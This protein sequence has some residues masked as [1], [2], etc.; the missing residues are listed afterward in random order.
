MLGWKDVLGALSGSRGGV[1][2]HDLAS[3]MGIDPS[4]EASL[5]GMLRRCM[6]YGTVGRTKEGRQHLY[7][8]TSYGKR[9]VANKFK[10]LKR[11]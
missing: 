10:P 3:R 1:S 5:R 7:H 2:V 11:D 4:L 9:R 6:S 8:L